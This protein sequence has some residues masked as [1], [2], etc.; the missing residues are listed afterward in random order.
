[1]EN[2][3][4]KTQQFTLIG[5]VKWQKYKNGVL[6]EET[7]WQRNKILTSSQRGLQVLLDLLAGD[8]TYSGEITHADIGD[9]NTAVNAS[10]DPGCLNA[11]ERASLGLVSSSGLSRTFRFFFPDALTADDTYREFSMIIDGTGTIGTGRGFNRIVMSTPLV[12]AAG[13]DH[14]LV[15]KITGA[16]I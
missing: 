4:L 12:K 2:P 1:M 11:L 10:T 7:P 9:D 14:T 6:V 13:E 8:N 16:V 5:E 3:T 15:C